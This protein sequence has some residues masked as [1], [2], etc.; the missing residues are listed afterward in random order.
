MT[1]KQRAEAKKTGPMSGTEAEVGLS[2]V[3]REL[4]SGVIDPQHARAAASVVG[5]LISLSAQRME[6]DVRN[7][8]KPK[9][10]FLES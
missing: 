2:N 10:A 3:F 1:A 4:R 7:G 5:K 6:Y 9:V 8:R